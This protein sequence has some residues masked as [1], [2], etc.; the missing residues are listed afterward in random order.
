MVL[1]LT[2]NTVITM[3][4]ECSFASLGKECSFASLGKVI[5]YIS[6]WQGLS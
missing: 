5:E 3:G 1:E 6:A 2:C 4:E